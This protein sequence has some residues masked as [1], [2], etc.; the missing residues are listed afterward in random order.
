ME[1]F[2]K[3]F[4]KLTHLFQLCHYTSIS[5]VIKSKFEM[6][7]TNFSILADIHHLLS[8]QTGSS[9]CFV[10]AQQSFIPSD[11]T[12]DDICFNTSAKGPYKLKVTLKLIS[13]DS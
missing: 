7:L 6:S 8:V 2:P 11:I 1:L 9:I 5:D 13:I 12:A 3:M 4:F 10:P